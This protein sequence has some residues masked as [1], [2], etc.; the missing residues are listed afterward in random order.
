MRPWW[1]SIYVT[2]GS[3]PYLF[4]IRSNSDRRQSVRSMSL[5]RGSC[6]LDTSSV[7]CT[8][9]GNCLWSPIM[10]NFLITG[11]SLWVAESSGSRCG[12]SICDA[13]S[14]M[15]RSNCLSWNS[16]CCDVS[17]AV[18][19][20]KTRAACNACL[21]SSSLCIPETLSLSRYGRLSC[22]VDSLL[23]MRM[24][25]IPSSISFPQIS[26]TALLVYDMSSTAV[27][28]S[29]SCSLTVVISP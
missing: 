23:P 22:E 29:A 10:T 12:S 25:S 13:S 2:R 16:D 3:L 17:D 19:P 8:T 15:A 9:A 21:T 20:T 5:S 7:C 27:P 14:M 6:T 24:K 26:S 1:V 28:S 18:V 11:S 4:S